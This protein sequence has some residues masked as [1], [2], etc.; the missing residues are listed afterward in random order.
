MTKKYYLI[1]ELN[2]NALIKGRYKRYKLRFKFYIKKCQWDRKNESKCI[3]NEEQMNYVL[4]TSYVCLQK[5]RDYAKCAQQIQRAEIVTKNQI[6]ILITKILQ[7]I[8][9]S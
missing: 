5:I 9:I 1:Q 7:L 8:N 6:K 2:C 3:L 4:K